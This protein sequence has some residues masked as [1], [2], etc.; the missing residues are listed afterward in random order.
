M[1]LSA[2]AKRARRAEP[3]TPGRREGHVRPEP[4][5]RVAACAIAPGHGIG[6]SW[7]R[8]RERLGLADGPTRGGV[9]GDG[10]A[11]RVW[12]EAANR[13]ERVAAVDGCVD[14][15]HVSGHRHACA[16]RTGGR[17]R[18]PGRGRRRGSSN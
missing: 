10:G 1:R 9:P 13:S 6:A 2:F 3:A 17:P 14:V 15:L 4:A 11:R 18:G 5:A 12:D 8:R 7:R 16:G